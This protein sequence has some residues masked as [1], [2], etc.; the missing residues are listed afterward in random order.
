MNKLMLILLPVIVSCGAVN[1]HCGSDL[2]FACDFTFGENQEE[3]KETNGR[4][5]KAEQRLLLVEERIDLLERLYDLNSEL[6]KLNSNAVNDIVVPALD[7]LFA[8]LELLDERLDEHDLDLEDVA[9]ELQE[10]QSAIAGIQETV[11]QNDVYKPIPGCQHSYFVLYKPNASIKTVYVTEDDGT[12]NGAWELQNK[13]TYSLLIDGAQVCSGLKLDK[14]QKK[15][16]YNNGTSQ[17]I[18]LSY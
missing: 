12:V 15:L 17:Y 11:Q 13:K 4:L 8:Q 10:L 14:T 3:L 5:D 6:I 16:Y 1:K 9:Q 2:R 18:D 7:P